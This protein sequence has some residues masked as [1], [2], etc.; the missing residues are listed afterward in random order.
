MSTLWTFKSQFCWP[1]RKPI[2]NSTCLEKD[3]Q[4]KLFIR[5]LNVLRTSLLKWKEPTLFSLL[6]VSLSP[7]CFSVGITGVNILP[8]FHL[9]SHSHTGCAVQQFEIDKLSKC[10][11]C[12]MRT[13]TQ[14]ACWV[15]VA[16]GKSHRHLCLLLQQRSICK[17]DDFLPTLSPLTHTQVSFSFQLLSA[18]KPSHPKQSRFLDQGRSVLQF[19]LVGRPSFG[20]G[21]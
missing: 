16:W 6:C 9:W 14:L 11:R 17:V 7:S 5:I 2:P 3:G 19:L 1:R 12:R 21:R 4:E 10:Y 15:S 13:K 8:L 20:S 18:L